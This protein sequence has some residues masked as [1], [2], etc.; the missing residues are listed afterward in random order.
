M[1]KE[2]E[3]AADKYQSEVRDKDLSITELKAIIQQLEAE[4]QD[5]TE[6][7]ETNKQVCVGVAAVKRK[8]VYGFMEYFCCDLLS[9][10]NQVCPL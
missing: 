1:L 7:A 6:E 5:K 8:W 9:Y 4:I 3:L 10:L 2:A